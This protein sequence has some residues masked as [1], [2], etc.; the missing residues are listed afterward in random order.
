MPCGSCFIVK[1]ELQRLYRVIREKETELNTLREENLKLTHF[2]DRSKLEN[3][4]IKF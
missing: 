3:T 2:L 4:S 1:A